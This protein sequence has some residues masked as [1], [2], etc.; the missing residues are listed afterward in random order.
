MFDTATVEGTV[1]VDPIEPTEWRFDGAGTVE[2]V[3]D[4]EKEAPSR[5]DT[6]G[7]EADADIVDLGVR[8]GRLSGTSGEL[9]LLHATRPDTL[10]EHDLLHS[11]EITMRVSQ[12]SRIG[13]TLDRAEELNR[14]SIVRR[15]QR[16]VEAPLSAELVPGDDV[17]TYTLRN[18]GQ[19][20]PISRM[21]HIL[22]QPTDVEG[23]RFEI[24][25]IRL[26]P[27]REHLRSIAS[28][29]GWH[30]L[31]EIYRE[32]IVSR[33]PERVTVELALPPEPWFDLSVGT[34]ED[35]PITFVVS[36]NGAP[37]WQRTVTT[38]RRWET[39]RIDL[40]SFAGRPVSLSLSLEADEDGALGYWGA[41]VVRA[42]GA[43]PRTAASTLTEA[44]VAL[45]DDGARTPQGVIVVLADTLRSDHL[46]V[47]RYGRQT[48][49]FLSQIAA[50]GVRFSDTISQGT[51]TKVSVPT[52]LSS[53]YPPAHGIVGT[54]DRLP[55]G[56]TTLA[57]AY[58]TAGYAT[59]HASS[60]PFTGKMT[61]L[62][63]GVEVLHERASIDDDDLGHS[64]AKT[65]RTYVDRFLTWL[66]DRNDV[67]FYALIHVFDP[68][69]PYEPYPPYDLMWASAAGKEE[70]EASLKQVK[71]FFG[72][73]L[74]KG[75]GNRFP[76]DRFPN[77]AE[78]E[79]ADVEPE[80]YNDHLLDWYDGS[81]R[82]MDAELGRLLEGLRER[83]VAD[84][85]LLAFTSDHGEEFFEHG[86]GWHGNS[87]YGEMTSVPM[88]L[89]WPGVVPSGRVVSEVV[90]SISLMP[91][92]LELSGVRVP[93]EAQGQSL[94]PLLVE[95]GD[96]TSRGWEA[97]P[98]FSERRRI[99]S[100]D[101][102]KPFDV[103]QRS[104]VFDG[105]KLVHNVD[106]PEHIVEYELY[107]HPDDLL[108]L[109]DVAADHPDVVER[110]KTQL[111]ERLRYMEARKLPTDEDATEALSPEE[112][113][114]LRSL[115][116][117]R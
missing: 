56:V 48:T 114:R 99:P 34:I 72:D 28:G 103:D 110:L 96:P 66:D 86:W 101:D 36:V 113:R 59:F 94:V 60:V 29:P 46:D 15:I 45:A 77:V 9:A 70:H 11:I 54:A 65:A 93:D 95:G 43:R 17:Q 44:R 4:D 40:T 64:R 108:D 111:A 90:E 55:S 42:S 69:D 32:T 24:E 89:W 39:R 33:S 23:A 2:L 37:R 85:T 67:P 88:V 62:H 97:R 73:T 102:R 7:W 109:V 80:R 27:L 18:V 71:D 12:G 5:R 105:W 83:G 82:G 68:H 14:D 91:T 106:P 1:P 20:F 31:G 30:G 22:I 13:V 21:R 79:Q 6:F 117:L 78:L 112:L 57:E 41:P 51:W 75:D 25:S 58:R 19:S 47:Y 52:L 74:R 35:A 76:A 107:R 3:D 8:D 63:Q 92:L 104:V 10:D 26:V 16:A 38:P 81:I 53:I 115:G 100:R 84:N 61:N 49:P 50:D 87:V 98:A 116:Y